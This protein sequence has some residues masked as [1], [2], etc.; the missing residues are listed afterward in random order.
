MERR[1]ER[2]ERLRRIVIV[3]LVRIGWPN[4]TNWLQYPRGSASTSWFVSS[5]L[6]FGHTRK[7]FMT[8][9]LL[10]A[11][12][13]GLVLV[14]VNRSTTDGIM[15]RFPIFL[16]TFAYMV[17]IGSKN[18]KIKRHKTIYLHFAIKYYWTPK[19]KE[20]SFVQDSKKIIGYLWSKH[21]LIVVGKQQNLLKLIV[22]FVWGNNSKKV[23]KSA[24]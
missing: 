13:W 21:F 23:K 1:E 16:K 9:C 20:Y 8:R 4:S 24:F 12:G 2:N 18:K 11:K 19:F 3:Q 6:L 17:M 5:L 15:N 22:P 7:L 10:V 14:F